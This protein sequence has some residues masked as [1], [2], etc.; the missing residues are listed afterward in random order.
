MTRLKTYFIAWTA[1]LLIPFTVNAELTPM[2]DHELT[3]V[4]G[5]AYT[6]KLVVSDTLNIKFNYPIPDLTER[7]IVIGTVPVSDL[8]RGAEA[9]YPGLVELGRNTLILGINTLTGDLLIGGL[10]ALLAINPAT[11]PLTPFVDLLPTLSVSYA[12]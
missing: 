10:T 9:Q 12:P 3:Q 1:A 4:S 7:N 11:V 8:A 5:Q 2:T 6:V